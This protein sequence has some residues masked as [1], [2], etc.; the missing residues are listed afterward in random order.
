MTIEL[1]LLILVIWNLILSWGLIKTYYVY[2]K[3][4]EDLLIKHISGDSIEKIGAEAAEEMR[5]ICEK[6]GWK[7]KE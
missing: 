1:I 6:R 4:L 3:S 7:V 5:K 2:Y